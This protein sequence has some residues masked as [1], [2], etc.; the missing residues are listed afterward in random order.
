MARAAP[1]ALEPRRALSAPAQPE[2]R[3][4]ARQWAGMTG[5]SM[6]CCGYLVLLDDPLPYELLP[7]E[8]DVDPDE[9]LGKLELELEL[10]PCFAK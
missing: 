2:S 4:P 3:R 6:G 8:P 5:H 9:E 1:C 10:E 7:V